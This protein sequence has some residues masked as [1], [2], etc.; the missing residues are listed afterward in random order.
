MAWSLFLVADY[1]NSPLAQRGPCG[2]DKEAA[3]YQL[4]VLRLCEICLQD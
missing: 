2:P 1:K 3:F 4:A